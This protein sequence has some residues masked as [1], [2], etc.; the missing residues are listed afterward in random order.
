MLRRLLLILVFTQFVLLV[1]LA[2]ILGGYA[3]ATTTQNSIGATVLW[4]C[5]MGDLMLII[6][7]ALLLVGVLGVATLVRPDGPPTDDRLSGPG[8]S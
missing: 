5:A 2:V 7:D 6:T 1:A 4:W 3:L 8:P